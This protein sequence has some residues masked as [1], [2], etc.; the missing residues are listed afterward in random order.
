MTNR[1]TSKCGVLTL[2]KYY[3]AYDFK[4]WGRFVIAQEESCITA[5]SF[6]QDSFFAGFTQ[7]E[8]E[9]IKQAKQQLEQYFAGTRK[10]FGL[11]LSAK[12]TKFQR[13]VW[14]QLEKIP[15]G[16]T[17]SYGEIAYSL[18][19]PKAARA[20]GGACNKNPIAVI[21][22][23]HRVVGANG[24]LTGYAGG[25]EFKKKLLRLEQII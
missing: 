11:P 19:M 20:V 13:E 21:V 6:F 12:G 24:S 2:N 4:G 15:Y 7:L 16:A 8:T 14:S 10:I 1:H 25:L 9:L 3:F 22:P 5:V 17:R 18:G 23:C